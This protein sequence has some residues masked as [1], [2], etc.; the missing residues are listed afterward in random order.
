MRFRCKR[1]VR[2]LATLAL[3]AAVAAWLALGAAAKF[4]VKLSVSESQ[5][6]VSQA[7]SILLSTG[8]GD[9]GA[10]RMRL[11]ATAPGIDRFKALE[12][13]LGGIY[14]GGPSGSPSRVLRATPRMGFLVRMRR[15]SPNEWRAT[16][17]F[18]RPGDWHLIVPNWCASGEASP[19]PADRKVNV[20]SARSSAFPTG[21]TVGGGIGGVLLAG[22]IL[23]ARRRPPLRERLP[24]RQLHSD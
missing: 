14:V 10:C 3:V 17:K 16:V 19:P 1:A 2:F 8:S 22:L 13:I 15:S 24:S 12:L 7:V 5:P 23:S 21:W 9:M 4:G 18:P 6:R 20:R 11:V